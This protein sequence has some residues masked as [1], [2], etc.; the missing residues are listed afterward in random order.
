MCDFAIKSSACCLYFS[1]ILFQPFCFV[2]CSFPREKKENPVGARHG[3]RSRTLTKK[4]EA[5][6]ATGLM[7]G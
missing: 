2:F 4:E 1:I 7:I 3:R 5:E 6:F